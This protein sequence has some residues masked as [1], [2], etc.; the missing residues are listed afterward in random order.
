MQ[1]MPPPA[2]S[3]AR[4][5]GDAL[6]S[7]CLGVLCCSAAFV[8]PSC[9][10]GRRCSACPE[11]LRGVPRFRLCPD[12]PRAARWVE[13]MRMSVRQPVAVAGVS[14]PSHA[15]LVVVGRPTIVVTG[16]QSSGSSFSSSL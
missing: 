4:A 7:T 1:R 12:W 9:G 6:P 16:V 13:M 15:T 8:A 2:S 14:V 5:S 11:V 10:L 3:V